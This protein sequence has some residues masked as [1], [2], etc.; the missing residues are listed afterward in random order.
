MHGVAVVGRAVVIDVRAEAV[1]HDGAFLARDGDVDFHAF[2]E[3]LPAGRGNGETFLQ[4]R[5]RRIEQEGRAVLHLA[6]G[7]N[8]VLHFNVRPEVGGDLR[9]DVVE[10]GA[11]Q[12]ADQIEDVRMVAEGAAAETAVAFLQRNA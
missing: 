4:T 3:D 5:P 11:R 8:H 6:A 10:I 7:E 2:R 9:I 1:A 12:P